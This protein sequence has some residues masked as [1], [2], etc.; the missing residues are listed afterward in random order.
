M[1]R[2]D[3]GQTDD[4][5]SQKVTLS[6]CRQIGTPPIKLSESAHVTF[7][8]YKAILLLCLI[9]QGVLNRKCKVDLI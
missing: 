9:S 3:D 7:I 4:G 5:Q 2:T 6:L 1:K 8:N